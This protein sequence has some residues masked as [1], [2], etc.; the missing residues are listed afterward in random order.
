MST[1]PGAALAV[2]PTP[3]EFRDER[4]IRIEPSKGWISL[5]WRELWAYREL[6][7]FLVWRDVKVRYKQTVLGAAWAII[8]P[9]ATMLIFSVFFGRLAKIPTDGPEYPVFSLAGLVPW[10]LFATGLSHVAGSVVDSSN[11]IKKVYFPRL[12]VPT[13]ALLSAIVDFFLAFVVL[14]GVMLLYGVY[15]SVNIVMF[16]LF[17]VLALVTCLGAGLWLAALNV[18]YRDVRY[19]VPFMIQLWLFAS[20]IVYSSRSVNPQWR[21]LYGL[22]PMVGVIEGTRWSLY[23]GGAAPDEL[24]AASTL[25]AIVLLVTGVYYFRRMEKTFADVL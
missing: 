16:P 3:R 9:V 1:Q 23:G 21:V 20:P 22:N 25:A 4:V 19:V 11:L 12:L 18:Q 6:L 10:T 15:P 24:V 7:Y 2:Q 5:K 8:Q 17:V 13:G 14:L